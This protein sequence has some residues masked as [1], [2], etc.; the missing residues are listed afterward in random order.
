[1]SNRNGSASRNG[2]KKKKKK[3]KKKENAE[4]QHE[5]YEWNQ[6]DFAMLRHQINGPV[7]QNAGP[8]LRAEAASHLHNTG[9]YD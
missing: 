8:D 6:V 4:E 5:A 7:H 2:K 3:K 9:P 1:M